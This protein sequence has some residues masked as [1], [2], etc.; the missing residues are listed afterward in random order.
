MK[1]YAMCC[2]I[3]SVL[4]GKA[5]PFARERSAIGK[6]AHAGP[7]AVGWLGLEGD[8]Q[9]D[10]AVHGGPDKAIHHYPGD[11]YDFWRVILGS[12]PL[13]DAPGAFGENVATY[14]MTE[15]DVCL[16]DRFRLGSALVEVSQGRQPCWKQ[17]HRFA[18]P[19][20]VARMVVTRK[21]GWYYRVI[22]P[23][24]VAAG[25]TLELLERPQPAWD[26]ARMFGLLIGGEGKDEPAA[27]R[28]L[29]GLEVLAQPWRRK[30][31]ALLGLQPRSP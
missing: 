9:A 21:A 7:V 25:D 18:D 28:A 14:G 3:L 17:G 12:Q 27:L 20:I 4:T 29:A 5:V 22:E 10:L 1:R 8:E 15:S 26:V 31:Q 13:L 16:G 6:T 2:E 23:G 30:A 19:A 24:M 11:H